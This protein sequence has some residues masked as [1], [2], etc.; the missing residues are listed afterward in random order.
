MLTVPP[1]G[2]SGLWA[3]LAKKVGLSLLAIGIF[4]VLPG[5]A[6][7]HDWNQADAAAVDALGYRAWANAHNAAAPGDPVP[8]CVPLTAIATTHA[9][10]EGSNRCT[11]AEQYAIDQA[12]IRKAQDEALAQAVQLAT[13]QILAQQSQNLSNMNQHITVNGRSY[14]CWNFGLGWDCR[15]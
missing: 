3:F 12:A 4:V 10:V 2:R 1:N 5:T 13:I 8:P 11:A 6:V 9:Q 15:S 7:A 14:D